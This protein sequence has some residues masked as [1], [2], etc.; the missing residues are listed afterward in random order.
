MADLLEYKCPCCG[1][2]VKFDSGTQKMV[3]PF[4][5]TEFDVEALKQAQKNRKDLDLKTSMEG[6]LL[7]PPGYS[8]LEIKVQQAMPL[9]LASIL[10]DG[11]IR[12]A[13]FS[14]VGEAYKQQIL[15][16]QLFTRTGAAI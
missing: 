2:E 6:T 7:L 1:G 3:C 5:E 11:E 4:C 8:V 16:Q 15:K 14:K 12:R 13:S 9:W 10:S